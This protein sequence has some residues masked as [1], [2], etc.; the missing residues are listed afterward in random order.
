MDDVVDLSLEELRRIV[1][2]GVTDEEYVWQRSI[3]LV[4]PAWPG[5]HQ[6][7]RGSAGAPGNNSRTKDFS[8]RMISASKLL[9]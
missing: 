1:A 7:A 4:D 5:I 8:G 9:R 6:F 3:N 2:E